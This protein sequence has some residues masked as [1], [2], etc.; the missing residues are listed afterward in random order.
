M[1][2]IL[3]NFILSLCALVALSSS[4]QAASPV[5]VSFST[6]VSKNAQNVIQLQGSDADGTPLIFAT[7]ST[8]SHGTL[9]VLD[10][11]TGAL[12][13]TPATNYTGADSFQFT[14]TSGGETSSAATISITVTDAKTRIIDTLTYP[15]TSTPMQ[16]VVTFFLTQAANSPSGIIPARTSTSAT[17]SSSGQLDISVYPSR[18]VSPAQYYQVWFSEAITHNSQLLGI[19]DIPASTGSITLAGHRIT[20]GNL[21]VQYT[22]ASKAEV[23]ALTKAVASA[24][25]MSLLGLNP[26][27]GALQMYDSA[28]G[29]FKDSSVLDTGS[30]LLLG[31]PISGNVS[32]TGNIT[33]SGQ[34]AATS[35]SGNG[36][37]LT[38]IGTGTGGVINTGST[39]VGADSDADGV[40]KISLQTAGVERLGITSDG[41]ATFTGKVVGLP[42][43]SIVD[44]VKSGG[45]K[46]DAALATDGATTSGSNLFTST[47]KTC[48]GSDANKSIIIYG[49]GS[50][51]GLTGLNNALRTTI[52]G[53]SGGSFVLA[54]TASATTSGKRF[55][56]GTNNTTAFQAIV[57]GLTSGGTIYLPPG[58]YMLGSVTLASNITVR[59]AQGSMIYSTANSVF[60][61]SSASNITIDGVNIDAGGN[62]AGNGAVTLIGGTTLSNIHVQNC[63]LTDSFLTSNQAPVSTFNRHGIL[64]RD[65][66]NVWVLNNILEHAL[67]IK[68]AGGTVGESKAWIIGNSILD[69]NENGISL[70]TGQAVTV[71]DVLIALNT[72]DGIMA[73][74]NGI[75]IGD[76]G[77]GGT[78]QQFLRITI[79]ANIFKGHHPSNTAWI[80]DKGSGTERNITISLNIFNNTNTT[81][82]TTMAINKANQGTTSATLGFEAIGNVAFGVYDYATYRFGDIGSGVISNNT[83]TNTSNSQRCVRVGNASNLR[84]ANNVL[85]NCLDGL[86]FNTG[87]YSNV[88]AK[89]NSIT[90]APVNGAVGV[91]LD[92][93]STP[94]TITFD[95]T[96]IYGQGGSYTNVYAFQDASNGNGNTNSIA[97]LNSNITNLTT[98]TG[99]GS[100]KYRTLPNNA[101]VTEQT[102]LT[103]PTLLSATGQL[104]SATP[105]VRGMAI[106]NVSNTSA[107]TVTAINNCSPGRTV[108]FLFTNGNTTFQNNSNLQLSRQITTVDTTTGV[109]NYATNDFVGT[110]NDTLVMICTQSG[111]LQEINRSVN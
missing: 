13:Y 103:I 93:Q 109:P 36:A 29:K 22:F 43:D 82:T 75:T 73:T 80:Q 34:V 25:L 101:L 85:N 62:P 81:E 107:T 6:D 2:R 44:A 11:T 38:G 57:T 17:L 78:S 83:V 18:T 67:R 7:T 105:D 108:T 14:V 55:V 30:A 79:T 61:F 111:T 12:V 47:S 99:L 27:N 37:G 40:G 35:F 45:I 52:T 19:Y 50:V 102:P 46:A 106:V 94:A 72:I 77:G 100:F 33:A 24:T 39:T 16:G 76:D 86:Y 68:A 31:R 1:R 42:L 98:T 104:N 20:N 51:S 65:Y 63:Y 28:T 23:D 97:Y 3:I 74:G 66:T 95:S 8:P 32:V 70:L 10:T 21:A 91:Y 60:P 84:I 26:T 71:S 87:T 9:S 58:Q 90:L 5:A 53:C 49:A 89:D 96:V 92:T 56:Y 48:T 4:A 41:T 64:L 110:G 54:V 59:A 15:G 88:V 69:T